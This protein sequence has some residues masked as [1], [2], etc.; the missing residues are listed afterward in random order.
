MFSNKPDYESDS[1]KQEQVDKYIT[2]FLKVFSP[3]DIKSI[4]N[5]EILADSLLNILSEEKAKQ[6][7]NILK[8][9]DDFDF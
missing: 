3:E 9:E 8:G 4:H 6:L 5:I 1:W 7:G 2:R